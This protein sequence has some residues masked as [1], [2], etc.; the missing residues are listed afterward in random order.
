MIVCSKLEQNAIKND[1]VENGDDVIGNH[2]F[3]AYA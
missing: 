2:S 1:D 3:L